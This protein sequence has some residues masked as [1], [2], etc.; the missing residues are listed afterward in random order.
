[1]ALAA[2]RTDAGRD[3]VADAREAADAAEALLADATLAVRRRV[4]RDGKVA[5]R[6][7]DREQ[8]ATHGLA[9]LATY[10]QA[11]RQLAAYAERMRAA[12]RLGAVEDLVVRVGLGEYLAQMIGGIPMSQGE[13]ARPSDLG[14]AAAAVAA[15]A[16]PCGRR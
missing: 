2:S 15:R 5:A 12:G 6:L 14:L 8:R 13:F 4:T 3:L 16:T 1:M 11:V 9:W 7:I 10:A